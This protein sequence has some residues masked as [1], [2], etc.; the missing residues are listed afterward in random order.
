MEYYVTFEDGTSTYLEHHGIKGMK[1]GVRNSETLAKYAGSGSERSAWRSSKKAARRMNQLDKERAILGRRS[2]YAEM[3][4]HNAKTALEKARKNGKERRAQKLA[5]SSKMYDAEV[6]KYSARR[7]EIQK[8]Y[9]SLGKQIL[10][11]GHELRVT[12]ITRSTMTKGEK[13][14]NVALVALQSM[15]PSPVVFYANPR[16][17]GQKFD[18]QK[19]QKRVRANQFYATKKDFE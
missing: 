10:K 13:A 15:S 12:N 19:K 7:S 18:V 6:Q 4:A 1:W 3:N 14:A 17:A 9:K 8:E 2:Q 5:E 16:T 11:N